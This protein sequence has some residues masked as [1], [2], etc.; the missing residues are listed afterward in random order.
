LFCRS[1]SYLKAADEPLNASL[2]GEEAVKSYDLGYRPA[3]GGT[4]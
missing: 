3:I 4:R 1:I 2:A